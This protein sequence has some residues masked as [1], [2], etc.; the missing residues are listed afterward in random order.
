[1]YSFIFF[2]FRTNQ[3]PGGEEVLIEAAG[4]DG[5][6]KNIFDMLSILSS[7]VWIIF[8][9]IAATKEFND[10]G[11]SEAAMWVRLQY[12]RPALWKQ[13][14]GREC[15]I[16]GDD[17]KQKSFAICISRGYEDMASYEDMAL[18]W[19]VAWKK[20]NLK[21]AKSIWN[22]FESIWKYQLLDL[23]MYLENRIFR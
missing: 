19:Q 23:F 10:V 13:N 15:K 2:R 8:S 20:F 7:E 18:W 6:I 12:K 1:M 16:S 17:L 5:N 3:H 21:I 9:T 4:K 11:H 14:F 22:H